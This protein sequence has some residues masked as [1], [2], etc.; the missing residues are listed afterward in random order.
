MRFPRDRIGAPQAIDPIGVPDGIR[1]RV[2]A[3]KGR[4]PGPLD[5]GDAVAGSEAE[6]RHT[7]ATEGAQITRP[8]ATGQSA[9]RAPRF[10]PR[11]IS[12]RAARR[13]SPGAAPAPRPNQGRTA[14]GP[15]DP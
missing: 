8:G 11:M 5:D 3:V 1:T 2:T 14:A 10:S 15:A 7:Q 12:P 6:H 9:R 13:R 4:C